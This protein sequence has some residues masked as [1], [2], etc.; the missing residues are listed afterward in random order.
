M[1]Q[2]Y[3]FILEMNC[4][5]S[6]GAAKD[7]SPQRKL[8]D[9]DYKMASPGRG[10]RILRYR[11]FFRRSAALALLRFDPRLM[12]WATFCRCSAA[13]LENLKKQIHMA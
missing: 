8:W 5:I 9:H 6:R 11:F 12:P 2:N 1:K 13:I 10:E 3:D 7:S 4:E